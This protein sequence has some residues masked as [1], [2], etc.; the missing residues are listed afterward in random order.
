MRVMMAMEYSDSATVGRMR[1]T[2]TS[3]SAVQSPRMM[4]SSMKK[5]V[6]PVGWSRGVTRPLD[7]STCRMPANSKMSRMPDQ[8]MG[9]DTPTRAT[10]MLTLSASLFFLTAA[11]TPRATPRS[12]ATM[13][14]Q[15][16]SSAVAGKRAAISAVTGWCV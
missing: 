8:K 3:P 11:K 12:D 2:S 13:M 5:P 15:M 1:W 4:V 7:G 10:T 6:P 14:A 9:M 16:A